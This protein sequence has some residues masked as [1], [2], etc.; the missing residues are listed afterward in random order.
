ETRLF[1]HWLT[2]ILLLSSPSLGYST[3]KR[4]G[5]ERLVGVLDCHTD[6]VPI[7]LNCQCDRF[8][9]LALVAVQDNVRCRLGQRQ[10]E[11]ED[12]VFIVR[13][14]MPALMANHFGDAVPS[15]LSEE[16]KNTPPDE[17]TG[18]A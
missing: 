4:L 1:V 6:L 8:V 18:G 11:P 17:A 16:T 3:Q 13:L 14:R 15:G 5:I 12:Q 9:L 10:R 7:Q 2:F